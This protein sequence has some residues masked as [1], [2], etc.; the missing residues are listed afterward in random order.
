MFLINSTFL[1]NFINFNILFIL[2][3]VFDLTQVTLLC[4]LI[5]QTAQEKKSMETRRRRKINNVLKL[6]FIYILSIYFL[7]FKIII[8]R[9]ERACTSFICRPQLLIIFKLLSFFRLFLNFT[10]LL[11]DF[12]SRQLKFL[13]YFFF[14]FQQKKIS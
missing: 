8:N 12:L 11:I 13:K 4:T 9:R 14:K 3:I 10:M 1:Q 6:Y 2:L 5:A 7:K